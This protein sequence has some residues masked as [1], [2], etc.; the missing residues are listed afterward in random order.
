MKSLARLHVSWPNLETDFKQ[1][2][3]DC[4]DCQASRR[5]TPLKASN[6]WIWPTCLWPCL[7]FLFRW[8]FYGGM[9]LLVVGAK[10]KWL[11]VIPMFFTIAKLIIKVLH[12]LFAMHG[13][14][15]EVAADNSPQFVT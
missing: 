13:L 2:A 9:F 7:H 3:R 15:E 11:E 10:S 1:T 4:S 5:R 14:P 6:P 8:S 12:G